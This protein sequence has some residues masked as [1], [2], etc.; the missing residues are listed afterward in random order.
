MKSSLVEDFNLLF[1]SSRKI[2]AKGKIIES[3]MTFYVNKGTCYLLLFLIICFSFLSV[4][5]FQ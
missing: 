4:L 1:C 2:Q 3:L 5:S